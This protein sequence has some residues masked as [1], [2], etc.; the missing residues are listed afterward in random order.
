M[1]VSSRKQQVAA[2]GGAQKAITALFRLIAER[3]GM[4]LLGLRDGENIPARARAEVRALVRRVVEAQF[5]AR[6]ALDE[7]D[8]EA[9]A[10]RLRALI[11]RA[12]NA[13]DGRAE[14][15]EAMLRERLATLT[16]GGVALW[17]FGQDGQALT[18]YA[19]IIAEGTAQA[20]QGALT[21]HAEVM[22]QLLAHD[23]ALIG[24][25]ETGTRIPRETLLRF[26]S[27]LDWP[28]V[29]GYALSDRIWAVSESTVARIDALIGEGIAQGRAAVDI[30]QDLE[31]FLLP[32]RRGVVTRRPYGTVGSFD[33]RRLARSEITRAHSVASYVGGVSNRFVTRAHY[34]LSGAHN[35][36]RCDGSCDEH[37]A[38]EVANNGFAPDE[39][40]IPL[41]DSHPQCMCWISFE[42]VRADEAADSIR[43]E[44]Y[45]EMEAG[46]DAPATAINT[47]WVAAAILGFAVTE[48]V[49]VAR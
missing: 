42:T 43:A 14:A 13:D 31:R 49:D 35:P 15:R 25:L 32:S 3:L 34:H 45:A 8:A 18:P 7:Q 27:V 41:L 39:V 33:A 19:Q 2:D 24:W 37:Y 4:G 6:V 22:R 21:A 12:Q 26:G 28:D 44:L 46:A 5:V 40:P 17:A 36:A 29:R 23:P 38:D 10:R 1:R 47:D 9:E 30:A 20:V 48:V 11:R 16:A